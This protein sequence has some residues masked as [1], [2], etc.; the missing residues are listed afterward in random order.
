M[1]RLYAVAR[2]TGGPVALRLPS[3]FPASSRA[4]M[5][6]AGWYQLTSTIAPSLVAR[7]APQ[8]STLRWWRAAMPLPF[9]ST[10]PTTL[11]QKHEP[12]R[13][14]EE[15]GQARSKLP[16]LIVARKAMRGGA[17]QLLTHG[18]R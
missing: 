10:P 6:G 8:T 7:S 16:A 13:R 9:A 4:R 14:N 12:R 1:K 15:F 2:A 3:T 5:Y 17:D 18:R 11:R